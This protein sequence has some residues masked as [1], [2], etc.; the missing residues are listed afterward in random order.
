MILG[1]PS[2]ITETLG[3]VLASSSTQSAHVT[4]RLNKALSALQTS[5]DAPSTAVT[6]TGAEAFRAPRRSV[7]AEQRQ[8][9]APA[10]NSRVP[11]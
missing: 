10:A 4:Q 2:R 3:L 1:L 9:D 6:A 5:P 11:P 7:R 8:R